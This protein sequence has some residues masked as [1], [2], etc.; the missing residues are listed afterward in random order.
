MKFR[1]D[2]VVYDFD[3]DNLTF[4]EGE[5]VEE[6]TGYGVVDFGNA[7]MASRVKAMRAMVFLAKRRNDEEVEWADLGGVDLMELAMSIIEEN[8]IDLATAGNGLNPSAVEELGRQIKD[9]KAKRG[10]REQRRAAAK[11]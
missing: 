2:D 8:D 7:V 5:L 6:Y 10:N 9:R 4:D 3:L 1:L 11:K